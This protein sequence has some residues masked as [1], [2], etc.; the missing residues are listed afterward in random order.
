MP[1]DALKH[2]KYS[3]QYKETPSALGLAADIP[4]LSDQIPSHNQFIW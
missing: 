1:P 4:T 3:A 2:T